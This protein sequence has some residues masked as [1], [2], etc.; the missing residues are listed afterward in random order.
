MEI[1]KLKKLVSILLAAVLVFGVAATGFAAAPEDAVLEEVTAE[2]A[3]APE[4]EAPVVEE[5][6]VAEVT[7][8]E[9][10]PVADAAATETGTV[11]YTV[12]SL[13]DGTPIP[14]A[15]LNLQLS[16]ALGTGAT[17][18]AANV[19][20]T[21]SVAV[22]D[23][24]AVAFGTKSNAN[25]QI[26]VKYT[27]TTG[28]TVSAANIQ[29]TL[30]AGTS[31]LKY[32]A[33]TTPVTIAIAADKFP[34]APADWNKKDITLAK[35]D[36]EIGYVGKISGV[37]KNASGNPVTDM[38]LEVEYEDITDATTPRGTLTKTAY[39]NG[40]GAFSFTFDGAENGIGNYEI[41]IQNMPTYKITTG[42][43]VAVALS[44]PAAIT[45][46][47]TV[48]G[49]NTVTLMNGTTPVAY[50]LVEAVDD[51][52]NT[53]SAQTNANGVA[54]FTGVS[55][56]DGSAATVD[57][58]IVGGVYNGVRYYA[59]DSS[60]LPVID[61]TDGNFDP[62]KIDMVKAP[63]LSNLTI[64]VPATVNG[65][66]SAPGAP[67]TATI[68]ANVTAAGF[69]KAEFDPATDLEYQW[70]YNDAG[71][72]KNLDSSPG[73]PTCTGGENSATL[74]TAP[75]FAAD[76]AT[77][78]KAWN[79]T[80]AQ[81]R[82][83]VTVVDA[84]YDPGVATDW[85][86]SS[87]AMLSVAKGV[88]VSGA[89]MTGSGA[90]ATA[91]GTTT[92][93]P[94]AIY[95]PAEFAK[96][97]DGTPIDTANASVNGS[98]TFSKKVLPGS[99]VVEVAEVAATDDYFWGDNPY[100]QY[101][102]NVT[103][104]V[105]VT[106]ADV[107]AGTLRIDNFY[108]TPKD[109]FTFTKQPFNMSVAD[110]GSTATLIVDG[111]TN[112]GSDNTTRESESYQWQEWN[113]TTNKW[114]DITGETFDTFAASIPL[115]KSSAMFKCVVT[116]DNTT[117]ESKVA[118]ITL[119]SYVAPTILSN[120]NDANVVV[121]RATSFNAVYTGSKIDPTAI[122]S[123]E[124][125]EMSVDNGVSW[126]AVPV[127]NGVYS[128]V[129]ETMDGITMCTLS[130]AQ[131]NIKESWN[132]YQYRLNISEGIAPTDNS[133]TS[134]AAKLNVSTTVVPLTISSQPQNTTAVNKR[135][136]KFSIRVAG[137]LPFTAALYTD[138]GSNG[139][140][141]TADSYWADPETSSA[142][143]YF[144]DVTLTSTNAAGTTAKAGWQYKILVTDLDGNVVTSSIAKL[145][146]ITD[147]V[148]V[149]IVT[150]PSD[151]SV[152]DGRDAMFK[153]TVAGS[154]PYGYQ[155]QGCDPDDD[156]AV[157]ANWFDLTPSPIDLPDTPPVGTT[158][159]TEIIYAFK[160]DKAID[161][162]F[163]RVAVSDLE[164]NTVY[165]NSAKL[166]VTDVVAPF[167]ETE[168]EDQTV[169]V[170][171]TAT[172]DV[173]AGGSGPFT[174]Q[175]L[176]NIGS[177][178][179]M[180]IPGAV[181]QSYT[182]PA[183]PIEADMMEVKVIVTS[184]EGETAISEPAM[185]RVTDPVATATIVGEE[186]MYIGDTAQYKVEITPADAMYEVEWLISESNASKA[187]IDK[188]GV[189]TAKGQG[190]LN[191][192]ANVKSADG[193]VTKVSKKIAIKKATTSFSLISKQGRTT[194]YKGGNGLA[195]YPWHTQLILTKVNPTGASSSVK[196]MN[197]RSSNPKIA[198]VENGKVKVAQGGG[199]TSLGTVIITA[200]DKGNPN[201]IATYTIEVVKAGS[202]G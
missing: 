179:W 55:A 150:S 70:Q 163:I 149:S 201:S 3:V 180:A 156:P 137:T 177:D 51:N 67:E 37:V 52:N 118:T 30:S 111:T 42:G 128:K 2:A 11:T 98:F 43:T 92:N 85:K 21:G 144:N 155:W 138:S 45:N 194:L 100:K 174:Y 109:A 46:N 50:A 40:T 186:S 147:P 159:D 154:A 69:T 133:A 79:T 93:S 32:P 165:S 132:G 7:A 125:W 191:V 139:L 184:L 34:S 14:G 82:V 173:V 143:S 167:I 88:A 8:V 66:I 135:F 110:T 76:D 29:A 197:W 60:S 108:L 12:K 20:G 168:P 157:E 80:G 35:T 68:T 105:T 64:A 58:S 74:E 164:N 27:L 10:E 78:A 63:S 65:A 25:G 99:Y 119:Q 38:Q 141:W 116:V 41:T 97:K 121:D 9:E 172:F 77:N 142:W 151:I 89:L 117:V 81:F 6:P 182:S 28:S 22:T 161:G 96:G 187:S 145:T 123:P 47:I 36:A 188:D 192:Y 185:V 44:S 33:V 120:P 91:I 4:E 124:K 62:V 48:G 189:L 54:T 104:N 72:W 152:V 24:A 75:L 199:T 84:G 183:L 87:T 59:A 122:P 94:I 160:A 107:T 103:K 57:F 129:D 90:T 17:L 56:L 115:G 31:P 195:K 86:T 5:T 176:V 71:T 130:I 166:T 112:W 200:T 106:A 83:L 19:N 202:V 171:E 140:T 169:V 53:V 162:A 175:W 73:T 136:P 148:K 49:Q 39:T 61:V 26:V 18:T 23:A 126:F 198:T 95:T 1:K 114:T 178:S 181:G 16:A 153:A 13:T 193:T 127:G 146:E 102:A 134:T 15:E 170:G 190:I 196:D 158:D 131:G 101:N 113:D